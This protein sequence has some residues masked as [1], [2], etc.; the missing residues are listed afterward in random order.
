MNFTNIILG[1][2]DEFLRGREVSV[3]PDEKK[4][5]TH[6]V[7]DKFREDVRLLTE[8]VGEENFKSGLC[9]EV[10]LAELL[11]IIPKQRRRTDAYATLIKYLKKERNITLT[12]KTNKT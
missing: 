11:S 1:G 3:K 7:P 9:I 12:I 2:N 5:L 6:I 4:I 10:S 8:Y